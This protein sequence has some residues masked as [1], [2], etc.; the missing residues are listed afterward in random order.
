V[1]TRHRGRAVTIDEAPAR[2]RIALEVLADRHAYLHTPTADTIVFADQVVY[3]VTGWDPVAGALTLE[4]VEDWRGGGGP[5][6]VLARVRR[7]EAGLWQNSDTSARPVSAV[8][9]A[10]ANDLRHARGGEQP[11]E[12]HAPADEPTGQPKAQR[13]QRETD[14]KL[15]IIN[16]A[17]EEPTP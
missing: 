7:L 12:D 1:F 16:A 10:I 11:A 3:R 9:H 4:L 13:S 6:A 5:D 2:T 14:G 8:C 17:T 15:A